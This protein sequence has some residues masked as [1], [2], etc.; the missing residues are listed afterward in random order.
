MAVEWVTTCWHC[1]ARSSRLEPVRSAH[2]EALWVGYL[3]DAF[4]EARLDGFMRGLE[5]LCEDEDIQVIPVGGGADLDRKRLALVILYAATKI[6]RIKIL[7]TADHVPGLARP[8][9]S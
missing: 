4:W 6:L 9:P 5:T 2:D 7:N 1:C 3:S 8:V